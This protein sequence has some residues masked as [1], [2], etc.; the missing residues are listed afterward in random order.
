[1]CL[2]PSLVSRNI[3][4]PKGPS[5]TDFL[6]KSFLCRFSVPGPTHYSRKDRDWWTSR[7]RPRD[8]DLSGRSR[9]RRGGLGSSPGKPGGSTPNVEDERQ[10]DYLATHSSPFS[11]LERLGVKMW[12]FSPVMVDT[13]GPTQRLSSTVLSVGRFTTYLER[14][15]TG[16]GSRVSGSPRRPTRSQW[17]GLVT[18]PRL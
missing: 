6:V 1:M 8:L 5:K 17:S 3:R 15:T 13:E 14:S 2:N 7:G 11:E 18:H 12:I 4:R 16:T 10:V 9:G